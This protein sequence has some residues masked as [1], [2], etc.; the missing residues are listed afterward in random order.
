MRFADKE[1]AGSLEP[2]SPSLRLL[3]LGHLGG[4]LLALAVAGHDL[5]A[6]RLVRQLFGGT[7][8][9]GRGG[10]AGRR[11]LDRLRH[12][13]HQLD[14]PDA[15]DRGQAV[16]D[17]VAG[18]LADERGAAEV[19]VERR[20]VIAD[21]VVAGEAEAGPLLLDQVR[22]Q[23]VE[24]GGLVLARPLGLLL[25]HLS[26]CLSATWC[27]V[28]MVLVA[29]KTLGEFLHQQNHHLSKPI[30]TQQKKIALFAKPLKEDS[31]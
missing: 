14:A 13:R 9:A 21:V 3:G 6:R 22:V 10:V 27:G 20:A 30:L 2:A 24:L 31:T 25:G 19:Q 26:V 15:S 29:L 23:V 18:R 1:K 12:F 11:R 4:A 28:M 8:H 16:P 7:G 17:L 5:A